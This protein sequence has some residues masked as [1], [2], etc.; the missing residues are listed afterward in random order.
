VGTS[1]V[2]PPVQS[3]LAAAAVLALGYAVVLRPLDLRIAAQREQLAVAAQTVAER[4]GAT[5]RIA[6]LDAQRKRLAIELADLRA[7]PTR[8]AALARF[9]RAAASAAAANG[10]VITAVGDEA[11]ALAQPARARSAAL[12]ELGVHLTLRGRYADLLAT[13]R[14]LVAAPP[15]ARYSIEALAPE[16]RGRE[17]STALLATIRA[18]LL[19]RSVEHADVESH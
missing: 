9:L 5:H 4:A 17:G 16:P 18:A 12:A 7:Q 6:A 19:T 13:V 14:T 1:S 10:V 8:T 2:T 15:T 3:V 11:P